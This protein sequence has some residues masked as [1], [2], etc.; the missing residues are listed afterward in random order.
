MA[1]LLE[2]LQAHHL[3]L[4]MQNEELREIQTKLE[5][6]R[7]RYSDL[8]DF[9]PLGYF[10]FDRNGLILGANLTG[11]DQ[12]G[13]ERQQIIEKPFIFFVA[14][15]DQLRFRAHLAAV[16]QGG[17]RQ[18]CEIG[19]E[20]KSGPFSA[21]AESLLVKEDS[22]SL[23][24]RT[25]L[26]DITPRKK[27]EEEI[28]KLNELLEDRILQRTAELRA[29]NEALQSE[30]IE[31]RKAEQALARQAN[32]DALTK[33]YNRRYFDLRADEEIAR[34][35]RKGSCLAVVLCDLDRFKA[36]NDTLGHQT[37]D[38]VLKAVAQTVQAC[39]REIDLVFRWGG[40]EIV[41]L[42]IDTSRE[43]VLLT[44][45]R[46]RRAVRK[47]GEE[48]QLPLDISI[49]VAFYPEHGVTIDSLIN[50]ADR[51]LYIAKKGG[52]KIHV[53]DQEYLLDERS[54]D[55]VFQPV[56]DLRSRRS[57]GYEALAWDPQ[58]KL[59][60]PQLFERYRSIGQLNE[61]K[62]F[63]FRSQLHEAQQRGLQGRRLFLNVD[64]HVL[65]QSECIQKPAGID[66]ILEIS[67]IEALQS[68]HVDRYLALA[69]RWRAQGFQLAID[70]FGAGFVSFPFIAQLVPEYVK[71]DRST[72]LQ[73]V[74]SPKFRKFLK[75]LLF[76]LQNYTTRG[77]IAEGIETEQEL[78]VVR[79]MG[80]EMGQGFLFGRPAPSL[81]A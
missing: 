42:L 30:I 18:R 22:G 71:I 15:E 19:I 53:G 67:E 66:V 4:E 24:C 40:D 72:L 6:S 75:D 58:G 76:A 62:R 2:E 79:E 26:T 31:R 70:D 43:G 25:A 65:D 50:L 11:A 49:G 45:E 77:M 60:A 80:I 20:G 37:G 57:I 33:L 56:V 74:S 14:K 61:L 41:L 12:L 46:I 59:T 10:T 48:S 21:Q 51:S 9:A 78:A 7:N 36:I 3:E 23:R 32:L 5:D 38:R 73:A 1:R 29:A 52:E 17:G 54:I 63:C 34:A 69:E 16:F 64:F 47:I 55:V 81:P 28:R 27:A 44:A 68:H 35:D 8:Y 39:T 13:M